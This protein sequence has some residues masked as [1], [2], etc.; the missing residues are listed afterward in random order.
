ML[1]CVAAAETVMVKCR[2]Q[3]EGLQCAA[4]AIQK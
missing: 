2:K 3:V 4:N 1:K